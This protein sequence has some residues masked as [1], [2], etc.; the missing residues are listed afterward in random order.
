MCVSEEDATV[1]CPPGRVHDDETTSGLNYRK[2]G[3]SDPPFLERGG[4]RK[5]A[6]AEMRISLTVIVN[7]RG[8]PSREGSSES[9]RW[10]FQHG[11]LPRE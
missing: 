11:W 7:P 8:R 5:P 9:E 4:T 10:V 3:A 6:P 2:G 1:P